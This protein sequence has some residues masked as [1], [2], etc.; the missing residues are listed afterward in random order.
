MLK[1]VNLVVLNQRNENTLSWRGYQ[2][3]VLRGYDEVRALSDLEWHLVQPTYWAWLFLGVKHTLAAHY[4]P[5]ACAS[6]P[7][8]LE[9]QF[10]HAGKHSPLIT[11]RTG[12]M[13]PRFG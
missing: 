3:D 10:A 6:T 5:S 7:L 13:P 2:D 11:R 12:V 4:S 1:V 9:W 8:N